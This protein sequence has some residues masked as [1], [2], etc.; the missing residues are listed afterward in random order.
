MHCSRQDARKRRRV[1][2]AERMSDKVRKY[3]AKRKAT[4]THRKSTLNHYEALHDNALIEMVHV[5]TT[6]SSHFLTYTWVRRLQS[7]GR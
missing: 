2:E 5:L 1:E 7:R 6:S 3:V 4:V